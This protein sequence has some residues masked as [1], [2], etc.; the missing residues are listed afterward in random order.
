[1]RNLILLLLSIGVILTTACAP[2]PGPTSPIIT[3]PEPTPKYETVSF[4]LKGNGEYMFAI[5]LKKD[6]I[7]HLTWFVKE[8]DRVWF[9]ILTPS[10]NNLG[11]HE[12]GQYANGTL[13]EDSCQG[14][15]EGITIFSPS[16]YGW[17]EGYYQI[18]VTSYSPSPSEVEVQYWIEG[19]MSP[20]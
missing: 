2:E 5:H 15:K 7:L 10:G 13:S 20:T 16:E 19:N 1:M 4:V 17:G 9:H 6:Q 14:F 8:G 11:F 18:F 3:T 12:N